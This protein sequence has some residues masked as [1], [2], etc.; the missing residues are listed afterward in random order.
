M[1]RMGIDRSPSRSLRLTRRALRYGSVAGMA[2]VLAGCATS[3]G[4]GA[5]SP[6]SPPTSA[7]VASARLATTVPASAGRP[8]VVVSESKVGAILADDGGLT[9]YTFDRD[10]AGA[11]ASSCTGSCAVTWPALSS[12]SP[13][14]A[15]PGVPGTV[16]ALATGS[17][18][19]AW[20]GRLLYRF[21]GDH[22][23]GDANGDGIGGVWHAARLSAVGTNAP[24]TTLSVVGGY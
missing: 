7:S 5:S 2:A 3:S 12:P 11:S 22:A 21:S 20:N 18:Q 6:P 16:S 24:T 15:G 8:T 9:L 23:A 4:Y 14:T 19:V 10:S 13:P 17:H 1:T